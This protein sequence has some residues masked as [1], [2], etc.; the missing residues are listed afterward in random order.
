MP[1]RRRRQAA[2]AHFRCGRI[3]LAGNGWGHEMALIKAVDETEVPGSSV[4]LSAAS[5]APNQFRYVPLYQPVT[6][7]ARTTYYLVS[8]EQSGEVIWDLR[9]NSGH[10][11]ASGLYLYVL[12]SP[13]GERR[14][15][16]IA[17]I[18]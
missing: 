6:L 15:G 11:A 7:L 17:V 12:E 2:A 9:D 10:E 3:T 8:S 16:K 14:R 13:R 5:P 1:S 18:R 4:Y